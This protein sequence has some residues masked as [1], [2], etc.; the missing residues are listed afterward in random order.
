MKLCLRNF[1]F[2][3]CVHVGCRRCSQLNMK[4][5][6]RPVHWPFWHDTVSKAITSW[7]AQSLGTRHEWRT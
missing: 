6:D 3:N 7:A 2:R 4:W 5:N 1:V